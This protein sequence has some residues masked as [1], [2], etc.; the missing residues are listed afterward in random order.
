MRGRNPFYPAIAVENLNAVLNIFQVIEFFHRLIKN[1]DYEVVEKSELE[2]PAAYEGSGVTGDDD[3]GKVD[4]VD[5][6]DVVDENFEQPQEEERE[7]GE[8]SAEF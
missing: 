6:F 5:N 2:I 3:N 4:N 7:L 8:G 1:A